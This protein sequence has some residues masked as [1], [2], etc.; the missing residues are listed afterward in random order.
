MGFLDFLGSLGRAI[1]GVWG[2]DPSVAQW[3]RGYPYAFEISITIAML[4]G[5]ST[6]LGNSVVLFLNRIRGWRFAVSLVINGISMV[7]LFVAQ[8]V[9]IA[10][11][12]YL[13]T[14]DR[15]SLANAARAVMLATAPLLFGFLELAPYVGPGIARVLQVWSLLALWVIVGVIYQVGYWPALLITGLGWGVMQGLSWA[16]ARP[17]TALG[18]GVWRA[19]SGSPTLLTAQDILSGHQFMPVEFDFDVRAGTEGGQ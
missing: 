3:F 10:V 13:V 5:I 16:L 7:A 6:L 18:N 2:L 4:A 11:I 12:G 19:L 15:L 9:V 17:L 14:G 1:V 8:A